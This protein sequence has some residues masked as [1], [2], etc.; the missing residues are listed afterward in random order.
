MITPKIL[1]PPPSTELNQSLDFNLVTRLDFKSPSNPTVIDN[2]V[3]NE[4]LE[5]QNEF[6]FNEF[7]LGVIFT[8]IATL[9]I[10]LSCYLRRFCK[11]RIRPIRP[12]S[13][14]HSIATDIRYQTPSEIFA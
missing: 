14:A 10:G 6:K 7:I 11:I 13:R 9:I 12:I 8:A 1:P 2:E 4:A 5:P 3:G